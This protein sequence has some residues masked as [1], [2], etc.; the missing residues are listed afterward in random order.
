MTD[1][2]ENKQAYHR[3]DSTVTENVRWFIQICT[4]QGFPTEEKLGISYQSDL[5]WPNAVYLLLWNF[6]LSKN[7]REEII[8]LIEK[9]FYQGNI[10][11]SMYASLCDLYNENVQ[12]PRP[13]FNFMNTTVCLVKEVPH[14]PF[15]YYSD[16]LMRLVNTNRISIGLDSFHISQKQVVCGNNYKAPNGLKMIKMANY[17]KIVAYSY[18]FVKSA[19]DK[20][21][22]DMND[23]KINT[24]KILSE[25]KCEEKCY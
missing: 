17:P 25:A 1:R 21:N 20:E 10:H 8:S 2:E 16:S 9:E 13:N 18:G 4:E 12:F 24:N 3:K 15:V 22:L 5:Q 14:R 6:T 23:Y 7:N 11:P 19:F